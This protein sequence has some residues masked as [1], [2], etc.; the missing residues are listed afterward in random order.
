MSEVWEDL[1][2]VRASVMERWTAVGTVNQAKWR[3]GCLLEARVVSSVVMVLLSFYCLM[4]ST[5]LF[6]SYWPAMV[7]VLSF[8]LPP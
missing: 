2:D 3:G 6:L 4:L 7:F 5:L 1:I 8:R